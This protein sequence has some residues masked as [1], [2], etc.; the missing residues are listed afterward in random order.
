MS[1][2]LKF[3]TASWFCVVYIF[4]HCCLVIAQ[5]QPVF[6]YCVIIVIVKHAR[7]STAGRKF[8]L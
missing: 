7:M 1:F 6:F 8:T 3:V 4:V 5:W 2:F